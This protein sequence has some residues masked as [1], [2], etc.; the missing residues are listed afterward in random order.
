MRILNFG[1]LNIDY[2]YSVHHILCSGETL[3]S[4]GMEIFPGGKGMNQSIALARAGAEVYHAG[5]VGVDD[6][7]FLLDICREN[8]VN[9]DLTCMVE[10]KSGHAIIQVDEKAHNSILLYGGGN[11]RITKE[12]VD[13]VLKGFNEGDLLVLQNEINLLDYIIDTSY[14]KG[15]KIILNPSPFDEELK[16]CDLSKVALFLVNEIEGR[17]LAG[18]GYETEED[19]NRL[20]K[21]IVEKYSAAQVVVTMGEKG[22]F[23]ASGEKCYFQKSFPVKARD[24]TAAGDTFAGYL[25]AG[26]LKEDKIETIMEIAARAAAIAVSRKGAASSIPRMEE[27]MGYT[28]CEKSVNNL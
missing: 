20:A 2:V 5:I 7:Q 22:A 26:L 25:V 4:K 23:F 13:E 14:K 21:R 3:S 11:R 9:T 15:M 28:I 27:V 1:S 19:G 16:K 18:R 24:T 17:L 6:G 10:G 8:G 12:Y